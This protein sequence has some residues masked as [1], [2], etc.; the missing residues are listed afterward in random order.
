MSMPQVS[1]SNLLKAFFRL[2]FIEKSR[3]NSHIKV[4]HSQDASRYASLPNHRGMPVSPGSLRNI[5]KSTR[6]SIDELKQAI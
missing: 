2:G 5:L 4:I 1:T 3:V 6:V